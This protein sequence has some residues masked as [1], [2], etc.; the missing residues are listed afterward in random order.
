MTRADYFDALTATGQPVTDARRFLR[1]AGRLDTL[2]HVSRV[3]VTARRLARRWG[4]SLAQ[5]DVACVVHDL[6]AVVPFRRVIECAE[7]WGVT[8]SEAD[9]AIPQVV[10]GPLAAA[11]LQ[12]RLGVQDADVLNAVRYH[13]TLRAGASP[14]EQ[15]VF[16]AD[17]IEYDPTSRHTGFH[18]GLMEA[19]RASAPLP[20]LCFTYLEWVVHEGPG[21]GWRVHPH[22]Q[23]A[24]EWFGDN[25][26]R[27]P[28]TRAAREY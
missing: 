20:A 9:R 16:I 21:L 26:V 13:T 6:A 5:S 1:V 2:R 15:L 24:Y 11:V 12:M 23:A 25:Y 14:L 18:A 10:H 22:A 19:V 3:A 7:Q 27:H 28:S 8:L 4:V 17:K